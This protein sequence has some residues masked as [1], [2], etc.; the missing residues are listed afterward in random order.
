MNKER[1]LSR[2]MVDSVRKFMAKGLVI[3]YSYASVL[4]IGYFG[5]SWM[6]MGRVEDQSI[7]CDQKV[8]DAEMDKAKSKGG[9]RLKV[10]ADTGVKN[11]VVRTPLEAYLKGAQRYVEQS[12]S[13]FSLFQD[14]PDVKVE[15]DSAK[16]KQGQII[17]YRDCTVA[18]YYDPTFYV[19]R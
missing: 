8:L 4:A 15:I 9:N 5:Y 16:G 11:I 1:T 19:S 14:R 17:D 13:N 10:L 3:S 2:E 7:H 18:L 6:T 12:I